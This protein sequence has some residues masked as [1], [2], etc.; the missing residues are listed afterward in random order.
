MNKLRKSL[1]LCRVILGLAFAAALIS[2]AVKIHAAGTAIEEYRLAGGDELITGAYLSDLEDRLVELRGKESPR[3]AGDTKNK[4]ALADTIATVRGLLKSRNL[5]PERF[6]I[7]GKAPEESAEFIIHGNPVSF[8]YFLMDASENKTLSISYI[9]IRPN[10][11][12]TGI[13]ITMRVK[14]GP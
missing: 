8:L 4:G 11:H 12:R 3:I 10:A 7:S 9:N 13:D 1:V 14:N 5:E 2:E 6:R